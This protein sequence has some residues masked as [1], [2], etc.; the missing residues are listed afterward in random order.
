MKKLFV[1]L[2]VFVLLLVGTTSIYANDTEEGN[3]HQSI[4][5][6]DMTDEKPYDPKG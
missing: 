1:L 4:E 3:T 5:T 2:N 6:R